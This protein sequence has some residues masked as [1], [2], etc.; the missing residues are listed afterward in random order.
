[1][2]HFLFTILLVTYQGSL[3]GQNVFS[4][5]I[6][7]NHD[8]DEGVS[9]KVTA[10]GYYIVAGSF[11]HSSSLECYSYLKTD[12][13]GDVM[14]KKQLSN[15]P[16]SIKPQDGYGNHGIVIK[17]NAT[18]YSGVID[19]PNSGL[20][21]FL[22]KT[23]LMGDSIWLKSYGGSYS[24]IT[25]SILLNSD[26]T[27]IIFGDHYVNPTNEEIS[28]IEVDTNGNV[29]WEKLFGDN[30]NMVARQDIIKLDNGD[31]VFTYV[32]CKFNETCG[33]NPGKKLMITKLTSEGEQIWSKE[34]YNFAEYWDNSNII[35][36]DN[37]GY[38]I[39][40]YRNNFDGGWFFPPILLWLDSA[41]NV[42]NDYF[43]PSETELSI[44]DLTLISSGIVIGVG[45]ID[46]LGS[47]IVGW[48][49]AIS[50]QGD[51]IWNREILDSRFQSML[52][53]FNAIEES[54]ENGLILTGLV[55]DTTFISDIEEDDKNIW[56]VKLD[57]NGCFNP[58]CSELDVITSSYNDFSIEENVFI[59]PNPCSDALRI[60]LSDN[61]QYHNCILKIWSADGILHEEITLEIDNFTF[62]CST[63]PNGFYFMQI[64]NVN[65]GYSECKKVHINSY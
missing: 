60:N 52:M 13:F 9:V 44:N 12:F 34:A 19:N 7:V 50:Q 43:F 29:I 57:K 63:L 28:I 56:L 16:R 23:D 31:I 65:N 1:M 55:I 64:M 54:E 36:L 15:F 25:S 14:W 58:N 27:L 21:I 26:S 53:H 59:Y 32:A 10:D 5:S 41:G 45:S 51:L 47:G 33:F 62:D 22:M 38:L 11:C 37:G 4:K 39:S 2:K 24:D 20:D 42:V 49:F 35:S 18:F 8:I 48:L 6:D 17:D 30:N 46:K 40:F 61:W 3:L